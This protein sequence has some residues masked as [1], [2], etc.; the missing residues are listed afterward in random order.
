MKLMHNLCRG[1]IVVSLEGELNSHTLAMHRDALNKIIERS[2]L[3]VVLD[4]QG[5]TFLDS[6]G[7]GAIIFWLK[8]LRARRLGLALVGLYGQPLKLARL[9]RLGNTV[10]FHDSLSD[11]A[12]GLDEDAIAELHDRALHG[13]ELH[14]AESC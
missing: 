14:D 13:D 3:S 10:Q 6:S 5:V 7:V 1:H 8:R 2:K 11:W 12:R 4:L 9:L